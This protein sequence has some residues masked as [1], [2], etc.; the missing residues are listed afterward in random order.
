MEQYYAR[1]VNFKNKEYGLRD[2]VF[3]Q[4]MLH[5]K[6][7]HENKPQKAYLVLA[8]VYKKYP[9]DESILQQVR[10]AF[11][12][13]RYTANYLLYLHQKNSLTFK[14][15]DKVFLIA[16]KPSTAYETFAVLLKV[17]FEINPEY[18]LPK[19]KSFLQSE[20]LR[21][22]DGDIIEFI[23]KLVVYCEQKSAEHILQEIL[24][25][26]EQKVQ[27]CHNDFCL[28]FLSFEPKTQKQFWYIKRKIASLSAIQV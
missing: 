22:I 9:F 3:T 19:I 21:S 5:K 4:A 8:N 13:M 20:K 24:L 11:P 27:E 1:F 28:S 23:Y 6:F 14:E 10:D 15:I 26:F 17:I 25:L 7:T 18:A 12:I 16:E 2:Y